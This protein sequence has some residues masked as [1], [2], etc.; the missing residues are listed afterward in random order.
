MP[1]SISK[2]QM[3][4]FDPAVKDIRVVNGFINLTLEP[5]TV[6]LTLSEDELHWLTKLLQETS[7]GF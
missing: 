1:A 3:A 4:H 2:D 5:N 7:I 6:I